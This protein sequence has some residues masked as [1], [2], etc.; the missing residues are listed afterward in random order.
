MATITMNITK[1]LG[2]N[3]LVKKHCLLNCK[4]NLL[5]LPI[6]SSSN[7]DEFFLK[8]FQTS[9]VKM[10]LLLLNIEDKL[11]IMA[12]INTAIINPRNPDRRIKIQ[13]VQCIL[14]ML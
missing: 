12:D 3:H 14:Y 10:V 11:L 2:H 5:Y 1:T 6:M 9:I 7:S 13:L 4:V 8:G